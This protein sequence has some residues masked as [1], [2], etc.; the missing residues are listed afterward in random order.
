[1]TLY[2]AQ[3]GVFPHLDHVVHLEPADRDARAIAHNS[4]FIHVY[5]LQIP[6]FH[7][8]AESRDRRMKYLETIYW[9]PQ[10]DIDGPMPVSRQVQVLEPAGQL[11]SNG[12]VIGQLLCMIRNVPYR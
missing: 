12:F 10:S 8:L 1:M 7:L 6:F 4:Y 9:C 5:F 3:I 2:Q 11:V